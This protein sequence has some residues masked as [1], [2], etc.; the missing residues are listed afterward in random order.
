MIVDKHSPEQHSHVAH[1][2]SDRISSLLFIAYAGLFIWLPVPFGSKY[3]WA[4]SV[5]E[6]WIFLLAIMVTLLL[7]S[8]HLHLSDSYKQNKTPIVLLSLTS[9]WIGF[10]CMP[11]PESILAIFSP[12]AAATFHDMHAQ[13]MSISLDPVI[14][15]LQFLKALALLLLFIVTLILV[16]TQTRLR[17]LAYTIVGSAFIQAIA[18]IV[19]ELSNIPYAINQYTYSVTNQIIQPAGRA[20]GFYSNPDHLAGLLEMSLA[21]GIGLLISMLRSMH[22]QNWQQRLRH[23]SQILLGPKAR[24]RIILII[25][26]IALVMTHSRM[27]NSAFFISLIIAGAIFITLSRH[28][29]KSVVIFLISMMVLDIMIVGSWFGFKKVIERIGNT[30]VAAEAQRGDV[31]EDT[32][33]MINSFKLSG[34]GAGNYFS[35]FPAYKQQGPT[36]YIDHVHND[37]LEFLLELGVIGC[38]PLL[39]LLLLSMRTLLHE[40]RRRR[41]GLILGMNFASLMGIIAILIHS[42][43]DFNLQ[44]P[45]NAALF[46]T[47]VALP[48]VCH[49]LKSG[50][51][52]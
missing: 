38:T 25:L 6:I 15:W 49:T 28:A 33:S 42:G 29:S 52:S 3:P 35:T 26:C 27:G 51:G 34:I 41:S 2:V 40:L 48:F 46:T 5:M 20:M 30:T 21:V 37:Y 23:Y 44:V 39:L 43:V 9:L 17:W 13:H 8:G 31:Y 45:A 11:I 50:E 14:T 16:N 24:L 22:F 19:L 47:L 4:I 12:V 10:Q 18:A 7:A 36:Y 32:L 1:T